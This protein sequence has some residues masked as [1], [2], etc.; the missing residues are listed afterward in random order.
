[1]TAQTSQTTTKSQNQNP[2]NPHLQNQIF[3]SKSTQNKPN[4]TNDLQ[5]L[6]Q[7][8]P[9]NLL[10]N[11]LANPPANPPANL[12]PNPLLTKTKIREILHAR[13]NEWHY[14]S[15]SSLPHPYA[16]KDCELASQCLAKAIA[17]HK[18]ILIIGDY[19]VDGIVASVVMMRFF[20]ALGYTN[21]RYIIPNRFRDGY[22]VS[23]Q[24]LEQNPSEVVITVDNGISAF[25]VADFCA[26]QKRTLIITD[27]HLPKMQDSKQILPNADFVINPMRSDCGF[28]QKEICG[29]LVAWYLCAGIKIALQNNLQNNLQEN[30]HE[31]SQKSSAIKSSQA[32]PNER[33]SSAIKSLDLAPLLEFV[34]LATIADMMPLK[35]INKTIVL[36]GI[37]RI[38][39]SHFPCI[40]ALKTLLKTP[41]FTASDISFSITPLLNA[42]GRMGEG[43]IASEFLLDSSEVSL[44]MLKSINEERKKCAK[45]TLE[46]ALQNMRTYPSALIA[47]GQWNEGVLGI[48]ASKLA[49]QF[50][51][52]AFVLTKTHKE[53]SKH[54]TNNNL[55]EQ[56]LKT[57]D[58]AGQ[59]LKEQD[60]AGQNPQI[61][62]ENVSILKGS[63]R[64]MGNANIVD[65]L[66]GAQDMMENFG[67][68]KNAAGLTLKEE[69]YEDFCAYLEGYK[70][71]DDSDMAECDECLGEVDSREIDI[72]LL[73]ILESFEPY[74]HGNPKPIFRATLQVECVEIIKELHRKI[75]FKPLDFALKSSNTCPTKSNQDFDA[76]KSQDFA[77][78]YRQDFSLDSLKAMYFFCEKQIQKGDI[79]SIRFSLQRDAFSGKATLIIDEII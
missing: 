21:V 56:D 35:H 67:G 51:K 62:N 20:H 72:E 3:D 39:T 4:Q 31:N 26:K 2:Q 42:A 43:R 19:D 23:K 38:K 8:P 61:A 41:F 77:Q 50:N 70:I 54:P 11:S 10:T 53:G 1:M 66:S 33:E 76:T 46:S 17:Q 74:G 18:Q 49:R 25:E 45:D 64:S 44:E 36:Y 55:K 6:A 47:L 57:Q 5:N 32:S 68:H 40:N 37:K 15:L 69:R 24:I 78:N 16:L 12:I 29:A 79:L 9:Q 58:L 13:N 60:L 22:G 14:A 52:C 48:V 65:L 30:L 34:L 59:G 27:H 63:A 73:E 7:N 71:I 75:T 28:P